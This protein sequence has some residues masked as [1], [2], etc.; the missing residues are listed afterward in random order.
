MD[1]QMVTHVTP[2]VMWGSTVGY[3]SDSLASCY[4]S[5]TVTFTFDLLTS[6]LQ[7]VS[8]VW[9]ILHRPRRRRLLRL[10]PKLFDWL[11]DASQF[12][13][14]RRHCRYSTAIATP[15]IWKCLG[16]PPFSYSV[17][18]YSEKKVS[19][20]TSHPPPLNGDLLVTI[21]VKMSILHCHSQ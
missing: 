3:P 13:R 5:L 7:I 9:A 2:K 21:V 11:V 14:R 8:V 20:F 18:N 1:Y 15:L 16:D 17:A 12:F 4:I 19:G 6:N 10:T